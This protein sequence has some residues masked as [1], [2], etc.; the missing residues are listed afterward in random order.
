MAKAIFI[1][2]TSAWGPLLFWLNRTHSAS[3][4]FR[5][6]AKSLRALEISQFDADFT[7]K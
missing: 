7:N 5:E 4:V 3:S 2:V 6:G 1:A